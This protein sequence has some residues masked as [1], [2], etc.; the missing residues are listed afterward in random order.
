MSRTRW[1]R[2]LLETAR[3]NVVDAAYLGDVGLPDVVGSDLLLWPARVPTLRPGTDGHPIGVLTLTKDQYLFVRE[4]AAGVWT[5]GDDEE[6]C[7]VNSSAQQF[8][9]FIELHRKYLSDHTK[10]VPAGLLG[11][12][13][14]V[15]RQMMERIDP[16]A[17]KPG[18]YW[19]MHMTWMCDTC[20]CLDE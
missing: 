12:F 17:F 4:S 8:G 15:V 2:Q 5:V 20:T 1:D 6:L 14:K 11:A 19:D 18:R 10:Y 3:I 13:A 9:R 16:D 7:L